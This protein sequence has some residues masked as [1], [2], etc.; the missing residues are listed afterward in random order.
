MYKVQYNIILKTATMIKQLYKLPGI[1]A[2]KF[3]QSSDQTCDNIVL[4]SKDIMVMYSAESNICQSHWNA[5]DC[6]TNKHELIYL[7]QVYDDYGFWNLHD[8]KLTLSNKIKDEI[9]VTS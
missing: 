5:L 1:A 7:N 6:N 3:D 9:N 2:S 8:I 4:L